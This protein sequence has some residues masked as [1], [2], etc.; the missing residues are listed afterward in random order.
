MDYSL[1]PHLKQMT[2]LVAHVVNQYMGYFALL[3][4]SV[5]DHFEN[6]SDAT[7]VRLFFSGASWRLRIARMH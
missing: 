7:K 2:I 1:H 5:T 6:F 4:F 3:R